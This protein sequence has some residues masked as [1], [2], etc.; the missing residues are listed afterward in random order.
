MSV[1]NPVC[2]TGCSSI[3]PIVDF[4]ICNPKLYFGEIETIY[5]ASGDADPFTDWTDAAEWAARIS[6]T[7]IVNTNAIREFDV[8]ADAPAAQ[9]EQITISYGRTVNSPATFSINVDIDDN[10]QENYDFGRVT[11]CMTYFRVWFATKSMMFGGNDGI[12]ATIS[13]RP[14]IERGQKSINKISGIITWESQFAPEKAPY[15]GVGGAA[16]NTPV[17]EPPYFFDVDEGETAIA[18]IMA[19]DPNGLP[20]TY[21]IMPELDGSKFVIDPS[22]GV[23]A[24][25]IT[26]DYEN[27]VDADADNTYQVVIKV[28]NTVG[29][30]ATKLITVN[31]KNV[32]LIPNTIILTSDSIA[33][34]SA[35]GSEVGEFSTDVIEGDIVYTLVSGHGGEDN[36]SFYIDGVSL[37]TTEEFNY[38]EKSEYLIRVAATNGLTTVFKVF[39]IYITNVVEAPSGIYI[40]QN[41]INEEN[42]IGDMIGTLYTIEVEGVATL[43]IYS[44]SDSYDGSS[45]LIEGNKLKANEEFDYETK[46]HYQVEITATSSSGSVTNVLDIYV[47]NINEPPL[48]FTTSGDVSIYEN[49]QFVQNIEAIDLDSGDVVTYSLLQLY[50]WDKF[51]INATTGELSFK[52]APDF[53]NPQDLDANNIYVCVVRATDTGGLYTQQTQNVTILDT[54]EGIVYVATNGSDLS[55]G[56]YSFPYLTVNRALLDVEDGGTIMLRGGTHLLTTAINIAN[57]AQ[58]PSTAITI[59]N[60]PGETVNIARSVAMPLPTSEHYQCAFRIVYSSYI[61]IEGFNIYGFSQRSASPTNILE[62]GIYGVQV[63]NCTFNR[64]NIHHNGFGLSF[65]NGGNVNYWSGNNTFYRCDAHH[66]SDPNSSAALGGA[67]GGADGFSLRNAGSIS[68]TDRF[69]EC[70]AW[71]NSDDGWDFFWHDGLVIFENCWSFKNGY[72]PGVNVGDPEDLV[73]AAGDGNGFKFGPTT[74]VQN[75]TLRRVF[76]NCLAFENRNKGFDIN[77]MYAKVEFLNNIAYGNSEMGIALTF[78]ASGSDPAASAAHTVK[79]NISYANLYNNGYTTAA[80]IHSNNSWDTGGLTIADNSFLSVSSVGADGN[81]SATGELPVLEFLHPDHT[82]ASANNIVDKGVNVGIPYYG[83]NPDMG[84]YEYNDGGPLHDITNPIF[85][86]SESVEIFVGATSVMTVVATCPLSGTISYSKS[87][88]TNQNMFTINSSTGAL[89]L[90][91]EGVEGV[92]YVQI[93]ATSTTGYY[94]DQEI[95]VTVSEATLLT[96]L[97]SFWKFDETSGDYADSIGGNDLTPSDVL[98]AEDGK[99]GKCAT[100]DA[101]DSSYMSAGDAASLEITPPFSLSFWINTQDITTEWQYLLGKMNSNDRNGFYLHNHA[102]QITFE[103]ATNSTSATEGLCVLSATDTWYH[104]VITYDGANAKGYLNNVIGLTKSM[105]LIPTYLTHEFLI[106]MITGDGGDAYSSFKIDELGI[107]SK[108]LSDAERALLYNGGS[109]LSY[110]FV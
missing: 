98:M 82:A 17:I 29:A 38:E 23:L 13:L 60:Y 18:T 72:R 45:F 42:T 36:A 40:S 109:G 52:N 35:I 61:T 83:D 71:M 54:Q 48:Y 50:D 65:G 107:W 75:E 95:T 43:P 47:R 26:T 49:T 53:E 32:N 105:S 27:P 4:D 59:R 101:D 11:S 91:S 90:N 6:N 44:L 30:Y 8:I 28:V 80:S 56:S 108:V 67:Y 19:T 64:L 51:N 15:I 93:R 10:T 21:A 5:I 88:G 62:Y 106:G 37:K 73:S 94:T 55:D 20:L 100:L 34:N 81:R 12:L 102:G 76:K 69:I 66:N 1:N 87:G 92:Y 96:D 2:P 16:D 70:R 9:S 57:K 77:R 110:P 84:A 24:F 68:A 14:V 74:T 86:S 79:N 41:Y 3:L 31:V 7:D 97:I 85:S 89:T 22:T 33:E 99:V 63:R 46:S 104:I 103:L 78:G 58:T 25:L 39:S